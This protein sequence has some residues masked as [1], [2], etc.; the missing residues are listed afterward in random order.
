MQEKELRTIVA[1][2]L[3]K[4]GFFVFIDQKTE[5][6]KQ[7][8]GKKELK[9]LKKPDIIVFY[10]NVLYDDIQRLKNP[11]GIELKIGESFKDI[12][13][14][15]QQ[16]ENYK[17]DAFYECNKKIFS[18]KT[19]VLGTKN[20]TINKDLIYNGSKY[21]PKTLTSDGK[22]SIDWCLTRNLFSM[23]T[24]DGNKM[25]FGL[26]K[27]DE[28]GYFLQFPNW[29]YRFLP[30]GILCFQ[31]TFVDFVDEAAEEDDDQE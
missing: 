21:F 23:R 9:S 30:K 8:H 14:T 7:F 27:K 22:F 15:A 19:V 10:K 24:K 11:F 28:K 4:L 12:S 6:L 5:G 3:Q 2:E 26:L 1:K 20:S 31:S 13:I 29:I 25:F 17:D 18:L 16:M